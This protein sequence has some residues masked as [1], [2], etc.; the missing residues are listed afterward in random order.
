[1]TALRRGVPIDGD[2]GGSVAISDFGG[3]EGSESRRRQPVRT[4]D[5][6]SPAFLFVGVLCARCLEN[7]IPTVAPVVGDV[8][9]DILLGVA[10]RVTGLSVA[11]R[12]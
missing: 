6:R 2:S 3:E 5:R 11:A 12:L 1:M 10:S 9:V 8:F 7:G 4:R